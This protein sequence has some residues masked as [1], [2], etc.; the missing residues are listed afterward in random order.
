M[1]PITLFSWGYWGW[2]SSTPQL[3]KL[4]D[5]IERSRD[6]LPPLFV[7]VR[8]QR[9]VRAVGFRANAFERVVGHGRYKWMPALGNRS[10]K[11]RKGPY[12]QIDSPSAA[13][14]LVDLALENAAQNRRLIFF[15]SC[16]RPGTERGEHCH[17]VEV[18]RL[19]RAV[20]RKRGIPLQTVEWPGGEPTTVDLDVASAAFRAVRAG[21]A[22]LPLPDGAHLDDLPGL[23]WGSIVRIRS[24]ESTLAVVTGPAR[25][26]AGGWVLPVLK[27]FAGQDGPRS[28]AWAERFRSTRGY[29]PA[30]VQPTRSIVARATTQRN[31]VRPLAPSC[32]YTIAHLEKLER[33]AASGGIG[34]LTEGKQWTSASRL[35]GEA[36]DAGTDLPVVFAD[37]T[38]CTRLLYWAV[39]T[40]IQVA[41][42][43]TRYSFE[44][45][46]P[47]RGHHAPQELLLLSTGRRIAA[48]YIRPYAL[49]QTPP[50]L[51]ND[52]PARTRRA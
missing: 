13:G 2:G 39:L 26:Q 10:I 14:D 6:F 25:F 30:G 21:R 38:D 27:T 46:Q 8:I 29:L 7:D 42:D 3:V 24:D 37:A 44:R 11:T 31:T 22:S 50:F 1:I 19:I 32:V 17:R 15:C 20:G 18:A 49:C 40:R 51:P 16:E 52:R 34:V 48:H 4:V 36:R 12:I 33:I 45:L 28:E 9:S 47:L 43:A 23:A 35:L 5:A 41:S